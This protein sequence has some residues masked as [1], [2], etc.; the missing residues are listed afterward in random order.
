MK[1]QWKR[2]AAFFLSICLLFSVMPVTASAAVSDDVRISISDMTTEYMANPIGI[3]TDSVHFGWKLESN[4][5]GTKQTAY[6]IQVT[7]SGTSK[8]VWD[9]G[10]V[11]NDKSVGIS[12]GGEALAEGTAYDW[13]VKVWTETGSEVQSGTASFETGVT[14][15]Q[16]W[17]NAAFIRMNKSSAA[18][19]FRTEAGWQ[20]R[21]CK[22]LYYG[23]WCISGICKWKP[24]RCA[25][26]R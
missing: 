15:Q 21:I 24:G 18:P 22:T 1:R 25:G 16:A 11:E 26:R 13:T 14:N 8:A 7:E 3:E 9:S 23:D 19:V 2:A 20:G 10:K 17:K 12:Y 4:G 5:I 6:Q